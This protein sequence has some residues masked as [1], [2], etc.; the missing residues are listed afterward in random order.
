MPSPLFVKVTLTIGKLGS[1]APELPCNE[2]TAGLDE[3]QLPKV[4]ARVGP[5]VQV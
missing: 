5:G 4:R 2:R 1:Q 3:A